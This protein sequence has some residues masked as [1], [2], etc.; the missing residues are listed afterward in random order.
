MN[1]IVSIAA[2]M[3][4]VTALCLEAGSDLTASLQ[5]APSK[6]SS[7][8]SSPYAVDFNHPPREYAIT[9]AQGWEIWMEIELARDHP[10][11]ATQAFNRL[12]DNLAKLVT[13]I[14]DH[15]LS[16]LRDRR[17][18]LML[19]E[20][21]SHGGKNSGAD[22]FQRHAPEYFSQI[23]PRM[24]GSILI[25][26]AKNYVWL[27][28]LWAL[29][30]LMHEFAHAWHLDQWPETEPTILASH[31]RALEQGLYQQVTTDEG[32]LRQQAYALN[33]QLEYFAELSCMYFVECNYSPRT[34]A[35][36]EHYDP[37]GYAMIRKMW[38]LE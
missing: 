16:L 12:N 34:R 10:E 2:A 32:N 19:G 15:S 18:F 3:C 23:D 33:N 29:K 17:I 28:D 11:L 25:Y 31:Q 20:Q 37:E 38:K 1:R 22:F 7:Y 24:G 6:S 9:N 14:P 8:T 4:L 36:L 27:S 5:E 26:S 35:D 30:V 21:S 13:M